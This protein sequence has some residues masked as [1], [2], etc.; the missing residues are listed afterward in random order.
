MCSTPY[1]HIYS[2]LYSHFKSLVILPSRVPLKKEKRKAISQYFHSICLLRSLF[3]VTGP[4]VQTEINIFQ[5]GT[6]HKKDGRKEKIP[7]KQKFHFS[8]SHLFTFFRGVS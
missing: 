5:T 3:V 2:E 7:K 4:Q 8:V 1:V 6:W